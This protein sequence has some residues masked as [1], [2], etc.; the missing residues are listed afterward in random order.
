MFEIL[1]HI[2]IL[3]KCNIVIIIF[4]YFLTSYTV[5]ILKFFFLQFIYK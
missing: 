2:V 1:E 5:L 3:I 4:L